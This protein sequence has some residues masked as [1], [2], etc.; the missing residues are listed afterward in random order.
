MAEGVMTD[1]LIGDYYIFHFYLPRRVCTTRTRAWGSQP[2]GVGSI[3]GSFATEG[4]WRGKA[5]V[6]CHDDIEIF[7]L[8]DL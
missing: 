8:A 5:C 4:T 3:E 7:V 2:R 6:S 1:D